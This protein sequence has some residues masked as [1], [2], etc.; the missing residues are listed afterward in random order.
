[1]SNG[2]LYI[3]GLLTLNGPANGVWTIY[4]DGALTG[5]NFSVEM[6]GGGQP[7][8]VYWLPRLAATLTT[9]QMKGNILAGDDTLGS[10]KLFHRS[11]E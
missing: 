9:S 1:M 4:V 5:T 3:A 8:N 7:C 2:L 11:A 10:I 6:A